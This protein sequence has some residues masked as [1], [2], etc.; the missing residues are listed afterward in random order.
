MND[1][2]VMTGVFTAKREFSGTFNE[3]KIDRGVRRGIH[4]FRIN[5][6]ENVVPVRFEG[7][8]HDEAPSPKIG[9]IY[10][11]RTREMR[12]AFLKEN[13]REV[14]ENNL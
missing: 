1:M 4:D 6:M 10:V 7:E 5:V 8:F 3:Q 11:F 12:D 2:G 9:V 14:L 13:F